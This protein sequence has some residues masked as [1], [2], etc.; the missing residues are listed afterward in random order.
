MLSAG[1]LISIFLWKQIY[2]LSASLSHEA[3][4]EALSIPAVTNR[5][6]SLIV[7]FPLLFVIIFKAF[8]RSLNVLLL[9]FSR[10]SI[11]SS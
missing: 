5:F 2:E 9:I 1:F 11:F 4:N 10:M 3:G 8:L 7:N 6:Y